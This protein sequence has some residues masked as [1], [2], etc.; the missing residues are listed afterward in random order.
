MLKFVLLLASLGVA[1]ALGAGSATGSSTQ[2]LNPGTTLCAGTYGGT[3]TD[4]IV[5]SG[6]QCTLLPGTVVAHDVTVRSGGTFVADPNCTSCGGSCSGCGVTVR[7]DV[8]VAD[9]VLVAETC[10][11]CDAA[12]PLTVG[13]D[14][15]LQSAG[16]S[17]VCGSSVSH[18]FSVSGSWTQELRI[19]D[20]STPPNPCAGS[21]IGHD[22]SFRGTGPAVVTDNAA[23]HTASCTQ[24]ADQTIYGNSAAS[25]RNTCAPFEEGTVGAAPRPGLT[26]SSIAGVKLGM[27]KAQVKAILGAAK[28][29]SGTYDNPGQPDWTALVFAAP[30]VSVYFDKGSDKAIMVTTWSNAIKTAQGAGGCTNLSKLKQLY[31]GK[32]KPTNVNQGKAGAYILGKHLVFGFDGPPGYPSKTVTAVGL[33]DGTKAMTNYASFVT[34]SEENCY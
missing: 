23:G 12:Q 19:G 4:V 7:H 25:G 32:L 27:S 34:L 18:D 21:R 20:S 10:A 24:G 15:S 2:T 13:H 17:A 3:G 16:G 5:P 31:P 6:A 33:F 30:E 28:K 9:G 26:Q 22:L 11:S 29:Q 8:T 14:L 1:L